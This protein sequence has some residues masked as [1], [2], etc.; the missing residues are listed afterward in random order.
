[1]RPGRSSTTATSSQMA[2]VSQPTTPPPNAGSFGD[3]RNT[4]IGKVPAPRYEDGPRRERD[5]K[6]QIDLLAFDDAAHVAI[7]E[8]LDTQDHGTGLDP[9]EHEGARLIE[10]EAANQRTAAQVHRDDMRAE[11]AQ[12]VLGDP[13]GHAAGGSA[14]RPVRVDVGRTGDV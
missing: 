4:H 3:H 9:G 2:N 11:H 7:V 1:M 13:A 6:V 12:A 8:R 10:G 14:A 5:P